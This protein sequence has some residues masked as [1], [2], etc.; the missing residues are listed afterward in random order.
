[1]EPIFQ[2][3]PNLDVP[4]YQQLVDTIQAAVKKGLLTAGQ[5]LP[6]VQELA[7]ELAV[8][9]GTVKRAYDELEYKGLLEKV[10]G[11][12]TFIRYQPANSGS[13]KE[14]AMAAI[15]AMLD[16]L[17]DMG[18]SAAEINIFLNLKLRE[19]AE[20][21]SQIKV[22]VLECNPENLSYMAEQLRAIPR[23]ELYTHLVE[24]IEQYPYKLGEDMDLIV[25]TASHA[26]FLERALPERGKIAKV[27]LRPAPDS[28]S[29]IIRLPQGAA[30]GVL[31][32]S[33]EFGGLLVRTCRMYADGVE[34][35]EQA[36]FSQD[37]DMEAFLQGKD[38][39]LVP[40]AYEKYCSAQAA[41][42]LA[43]FKGTLIQCG[44]E[45]DEGSFLFLRET[46]KR[47][48][49]EKTI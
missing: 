32:Y 7:Q 48:L 45:M 35:V 15:D 30:V 4:I 20:Q 29:K 34:P 42:S 1:M 12:G 31:S 47:L 38:T 10:Q 46:A 26:D 23:V 6:T 19:R 37:M 44:Y 36:L 28:L 2:I 9:R 14:Q 43:G 18:L 11:R 13:R 24:S 33:A 25:T 40:R 3:D 5:K 16:Q 41:A 22:A 49:E 39:V 27:A 17:E 8:A 21:E